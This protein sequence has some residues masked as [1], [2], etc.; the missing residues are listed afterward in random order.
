MLRLHFREKGPRDAVRQHM[1]GRQ[2]V[3]G[4]L[5]SRGRRFHV[6]GVA[7]LLEI[8]E[9]KETLCEGRLA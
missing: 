5:K 8:V 3:V 7:G 1:D 6:L 2:K 4:R 9:R